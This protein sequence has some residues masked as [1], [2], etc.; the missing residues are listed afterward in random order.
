MLLRVVK[1]PVTTDDT[2]VDVEGEVAKRVATLEDLFAKI[3]RFALV[4]AIFIVLLSLLDGWPLL[5]GSAWW[6]QP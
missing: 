4:V 2:R 5:P 3:I 1:V 6:R